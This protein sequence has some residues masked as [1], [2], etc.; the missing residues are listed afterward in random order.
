MRLQIQQLKKEI[1]RLH[2][3][4]HGGT[5]HQEND[6][7][8][9]T[10]PGSPGSIKWEG[11]HGSF[12][13]LTFDKRISQEKWMEVLGCEVSEQEILERSERMD[14]VIWA[15]GHEVKATRTVAYTNHTVLPEA[16]EK[17]GLDV[18]VITGIDTP[19]STRTSAITSGVRTWK[20]IAT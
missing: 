4:V 6:N 5:E 19:P 14:N 1:N 7:L 20:V 11:G 17:W 8:N 18:I 12:S 3:L 9:A 16:L 10:I 15:F 13:P 2:G